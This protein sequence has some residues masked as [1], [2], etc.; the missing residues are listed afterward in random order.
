LPDGRFSDQKCHLWYILE[1]LMG[2]EIYV[3]FMAIWYFYIYFG[4]LH[5]NLV[6]LSPFWYIT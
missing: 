5:S 6:C 4:I 3:Y 1:G 2:W